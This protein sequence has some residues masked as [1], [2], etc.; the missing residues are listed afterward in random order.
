MR[1]LDVLYDPTDQK[2]ITISHT[3]KRTLKICRYIEYFNI[4][5]ITFNRA[6]IFYHI[7]YAPIYCTFII[8]LFTIVGEFRGC[9]DVTYYQNVLGTVESLLRWTHHKV[10][11]LYKADKEF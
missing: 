2:N 10:D 5:S 9:W 8:Y 11:N 4:S 7:L 1:I 6:F 3:T